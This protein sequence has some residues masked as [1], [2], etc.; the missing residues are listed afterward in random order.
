MRW[1]RRSS[2][3]KPCRGFP[4]LALTEGHYRPDGRTLYAGMEGPLSADASDVRR[5]IRYEGRSGRSYVP[6][7]QYAYQADPSLGLVELVAL[8]DGGL[9]A[10]ERGFTAGAGNTVRVYQT[11]T[12]GA[13]DVSDVQSVLGSRTAGG[14]HTLFLIS[15]DNGNAAQI[16]RVYAFAV[17]L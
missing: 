6:S 7:A 13:R 10:L 11:S 12:R 14:R 9:L 4:T 15:D 5:I 17:D 3:G 1:T 8:P 2:T 16:T